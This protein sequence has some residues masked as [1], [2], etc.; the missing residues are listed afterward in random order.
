MK[1]FFDTNVLIAA[2]VAHGTCGELLEHCLGN[3]TICISQWV[4]DEFREKLLE[5]FEFSEDI[6]EQII[7]FVR[8][9]MVI[10]TQPRLAVFICRDPDDNHI[11]AAIASGNVDCLVTGDEDLL[12]L[13]SFQEIPIL[14]PSDFWKFEKTRE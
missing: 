4:L 1:I 11:L 5:K 3:H 2:F 14:R 13:K 8:E 10:I 12:V 6:V 9:N 7:T